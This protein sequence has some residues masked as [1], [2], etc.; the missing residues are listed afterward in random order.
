M[1]LS[2]AVVLITGANRGLGR[3]LVERSLAAGARRVYAGA[4]DPAQLAPVVRIAPDRVV[5]L[6][7]DV[8]DP[9][10]IAAAAARAGDVSLVINN[11]GVLASFGLLTSSNDAI[12][13]DFAVN[14]FGMLATT[15]AFLP[16]LERAAAAGD[17]DTVRAG[18]VN[19]LSVVS[20]ASMP[21]IG[22][23]SASKAAAY[24]VTQAL[25]NDLVAKR[26]AVHAAFPGP[27][28]T[29]M[30]RDMAGPKTSP[31][32]VAAAILDG[33]ER[34]IEEILPDPASRELHALWRKEPRS[35]ERQF[36]AMA[37]G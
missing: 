34:G 30:I 27:I 28:D 18:V 24:S 31:A 1:K 20:F 16:A 13:R 37:G 9:A 7:I 29:D 5:P 8:T 11:A 12:S 26:I 19:V 32:D 21:A 22:G 4:R 10:T 2:N 23:Y 17:A 6:A 36:V 33:V 15:L 35:L 25:R 14:L 3:A